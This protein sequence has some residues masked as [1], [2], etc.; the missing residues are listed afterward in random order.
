MSETHERWLAVKIELRV[1]VMM[2]SLKHEGWLAVKIELRVGVMML[3][4]GSAASVV[5]QARTAGGARQMSAVSVALRMALAG[6]AGAD[7][8]K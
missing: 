1:G 4:P 6:R 7:S 2:L 8:F 5:S 3:P